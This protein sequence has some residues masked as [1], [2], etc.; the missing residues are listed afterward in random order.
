MSSASS[1]CYPESWLQAWEWQSHQVRY[2][3]PG[4]S[5]TKPTVVLIHGF[6]ACKEHWRHNVSALASQWDVVALDLVGF[7]SSSKPKA[8]LDGETP[9]PGSLRYGIDGWA[10]QVAAFVNEHLKTP[11]VLVGNS[12]GGVVALTAAQKLETQGRSAAGVVLVDCAQRAIDDKRVDEQPFGRRL[13]RPLLKALVKQRWLTTA[14]FRSLAQPPVIRAVLKQAYPTGGNVDDTLVN[15]LHAATQ[16]AGASE[17]FRGFINLFNDRLAPDILKE[18]STP[19]S[20][21][22]GSRDPWEPIEEAKA[23][24]SIPCVQSFDSLE[25]LGHCPHD[26]APE[27]VNPLLIERITALLTAQ[28]TPAA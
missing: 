25:G 21:L 28:A 23:W 9:E 18:L 13:S 6:G 20:V 7:G 24:T 27:R 8:T 1:P 14:L 15:V 2:I 22:W 11:V 12:I 19:V 10:D 26:E 5:N 17:S 4:L 3:T 16:D